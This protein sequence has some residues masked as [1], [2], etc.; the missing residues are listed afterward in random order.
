[1][2]VELGADGR[3]HEVRPGDQPTAHVDMQPSTASA[4]PDIVDTEVLDEDGNPISS[5]DSGS[6]GAGGG[7]VGGSAST[8]THAPGRATEPGSATTSPSSENSDATDTV[9]GEHHAA[10]EGTE[11]N[12]QTSESAQEPAAEATEEEFGEVTSGGGTSVTGMGR[13]APKPAENTGERTTQPA[14]AGAAP[15]ADD[16][17][18]PADRQATNTRE[19]PEAPVTTLII[20]EVSHVATRGVA[21]SSR[22]VQ[23]KATRAVTRGGSRRQRAGD[24]IGGAIGLAG[25][26]IGS[27]VTTART[28]VGEI[29]QGKGLLGRFRYTT[30]VTD[31]KGVQTRVTVNALGRRMA[32]VRFKLQPTGKNLVG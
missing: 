2:I 23:H 20:K 3:Y 5:G 27:P 12:T 25:G 10:S 8:A 30:V 24:I 22:A 6:V 14:S 21:R 4:E 29:Y 11:P 9:A 15:S 17:P 31:S 28:S 7:Y 19:R 18:P 16:T 13:Q 1:V 26:I 32:Y